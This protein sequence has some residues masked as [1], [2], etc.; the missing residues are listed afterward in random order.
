MELRGRR[1]LSDA[2]RPH[3]DL[4]RRFFGHQ[5]A[6]L[7]C[8]SA[9]A[10]T[11]DVASSLPSMADAVMRGPIVALGLEDDYDT[12]RA[13][14]DP[15]E[16]ARLLGQLSTRLRT[17]GFMPHS[18]MLDNARAESLSAA[19]DAEAGARLD[20]D[21]FVGALES[22]PAGAPA[23]RRLHAATTAG[24]SVELAEAIHAAQA[25]AAFERE[26]EVGLEVVAEH[27][28]RLTPAHPHGLVL[29]VLAAEHFVAGRRSDLLQGVAVA[30]RALLGGPTA[31]APERPAARLRAC[32]ADAGIEDW[33]SLAAGARYGFGPHVAAFVA[34]RHARHL[35]LTGCGGQAVSAWDDAVERA[36]T[37]TAFVDA[38]GW[39]SS[40]A[41]T[42]SQYRDRR[43]FERQLHE[44]AA[45]LREAGGS[46][47]LAE[48]VE[49]YELALEHLS[50]N[51]WPTAFAAAVR[52]RR[53]AVAAGRLREELAAEALLGRVLLAS[54]D[55]TRAA[56]HLVRAGAPDTEIRALVAALPER[57]FTPP[58]PTAGLPGQVTALLRLVARAADLIDDA[59]A[60]SWLDF[61][62]DSG[63][64]DAAGHPVA[65]DPSAVPAAI[66]ALAADG[67]RSRRHAEGVLNHVKRRF[68]TGRLHSDPEAV[69]AVAAIAERH[70][71]VEAAEL[72]VRMLLADDY[73]LTT[74]VMAYGRRA[75]EDHPDLVREYCAAPAAA[76]RLDAHLALALI[77]DQG[78]ESPCTEHLLEI[79]ASPPRLPGHFSGPASWAK[80]LQLAPHATAG[81]RAAFVEHLIRLVEDIDDLPENRESTLDA[82]TA[83]AN[84]IITETPDLADRIEHLALRV[85]RGELDGPANRTIPGIVGLFDPPDAMRAAALCTAAALT[86]GDRARQSEVHRLAVNAMANPLQ[87]SWAVHALVRLP[88][89]LSRPHLA[90][91]AAHP[92]DWVRALTAALRA[93]DPDSDPDLGQRLATDRARRVRASL[94]NTLPPASTHPGIRA[95]RE[96]PKHDVRRSIRV[97]ARNSD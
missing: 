24:V 93:A 76:A 19:G 88:T 34:A 97:T 18:A 80:E 40:Q 32:L 14:V 4:V 54:G 36:C 45:V 59:N 62:L 72:L 96:T 17:A 2:L 58:A 66:V 27:T 11:G 92:E 75:L 52:H 74:A 42:L 5:T 50:R 15:N 94:A 25:I 55:A 89:E 81:A 85:A 60:D 35:A 68:D 61:L 44:H 64:V 22:R 86:R 95:V 33:A 28:A 70:D 20:L 69:R 71:L 12:A 65:G 49:A 39:C 16:R 51:K 79:A 82:L 1:W 46:P 83:L 29:M 56:G 26:E 6:D 73:V 78:A 10:V 91:L 90:V 13:T 63:G 30:A 31:P 77:G 87:L 7:F 47:L 41:T 37:A 8:V 38:A 67:T 53:W 21:A 43:M 84:G 57:T 23:R 48:P 9:A 3:D